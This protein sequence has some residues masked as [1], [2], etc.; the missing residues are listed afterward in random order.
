MFSILWL[1]VHEPWCLFQVQI[2]NNGSSCI[3][4]WIS[5]QSSTIHSDS[6][7]PDNNWTTEQHDQ[8]IMTGQH[9]RQDK[10]LTDQLFNQSRHCPLTDHYFELW[11]LVTNCG[12]TQ[13]H[14]LWQTNKGA[15]LFSNGTQWP[16]VPNSCS[17]WLENFSFLTGS[18]CYARCPEILQVQCTGSL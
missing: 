15:K 16:L 18:N 4:P 9:D 3:S 5:D 11:S 7:H 6:L 1:E 17:W 12:H 10:R 2:V 8:I 13:S 14:N